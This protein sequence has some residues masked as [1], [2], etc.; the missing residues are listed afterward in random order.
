MVSPERLRRFP[1]FSGF[2]VEHLNAVAMLADEVTFDGG[3]TIFKAVQPANALYFLI[4]GCVELHYIVV[5]EINS[6]LHKDFFV[7]EVNPGEPFGISALIE[8]YRF[9][10][11]V[12]TAC[13]SRVLRFDA[14]GLRALCAVDP[15]IEAVLMRQIAAAAMSRLNDTRVQLAAAR[16]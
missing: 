16:A 13:A 9:T 5:D 6:K 8:P 4:E 15:R 12:R 3:E 1:F 14:A 2:G 7:S 11:T 10:G